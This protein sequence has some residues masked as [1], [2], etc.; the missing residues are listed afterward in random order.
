MSTCL[1]KESPNM[2]I[3]RARRAGRVPFNQGA[4]KKS[5]Q[6][7]GL[8]VGEWGRCTSTP[9]PA[10]KKSP[11]TW[12][13]KDNMLLPLTHERKILAKR[14][15]KHGDWK[16]R[17]SV[18]SY[19]NLKCNLQ[20][21]SPNMGIESSSGHL[22][23]YR[24]S[25]DLQKESPNMGIERLIA[26]SDPPWNQPLAKRVPKHG[27]WKPCSK[28]PL[29]K[30]GFHLQKESPNMGIERITMVVREAFD[31]A[32]LAKRVPKHGDWKDCDFVPSHKRCHLAKRVPKHGDWKNKLAYYL[33]AETRVLQ[34][35]SP[36]M[37]IESSLSWSSVI[38]LLINLQK[39]S[40]N[41]GIE[42]AYA[43][44][45]HHALLALAKRVPKHGDWKS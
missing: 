37:G 9:N 31:P 36:N 24:Q 17:N 16:Y 26:W 18:P 25:L 22:L 41:M 42:S 43:C 44:F 2:G 4:C 1:Q 6:T 20:K 45:G 35:E 3:E 13:L 14:V 12:G 34:K 11:Q 27:D 23:L 10:C 32:H 28:P 29:G 8:K 19:K 33:N 38:L 15:P 5:P 21:E 30:R 40:P 7:W 39:E